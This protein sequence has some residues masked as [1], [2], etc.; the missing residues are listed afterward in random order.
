MNHVGIIGTGVVH[1]GEQVELPKRSFLSFLSGQD[2]SEPTVVQ[3][4]HAAACKA[5]SQAGIQANE[6]D[7]ILG[8][9]T[10][11]TNFSPGTTQVAPRLSWGV[12]KLLEARN[13]YAFDICTPDSLLSIET[14]QTHVRTGRARI[15]LVV[16]AEQFRDDLVDVHSSSHVQLLTGAAASVIGTGQTCLHLIASSY[17]IAK[18]E[19]GSLTLDLVYGEQAPFRPRVAFNQGDEDKCATAMADTAVE[20]LSR[21]LGKMVSCKDDIDYFLLPRWNNFFRTRLMEKLKLSEYQEEANL[22]DGFLFTPGAITELDRWLTRI[23]P[24][25]RFALIGYGLGAYVGCQIYQVTS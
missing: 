9:T 19:E 16:T 25:E 13:S 18:I 1:D 2:Q 15:A 8:T 11:V 10:A 20:Q 14:A 23:S 3:L 22:S 17:G 24:G 12:H 5:L 21:C 7:L 6:V 4:A